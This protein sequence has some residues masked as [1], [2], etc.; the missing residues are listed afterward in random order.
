MNTLTPAARDFLRSIYVG[1][2]VHLHREGAT[3][4]AA[5]EQAYADVQGW[6]DAMYDG[7]IASVDGVPV[8]VEAVK[9]AEA[10]MKQGGLW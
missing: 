1:R 9:V 2:G 3:V 5:K 8:L 10:P 6:R 4:E 7:F